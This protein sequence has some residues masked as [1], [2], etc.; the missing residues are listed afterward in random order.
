[1]KDRRAF[2]L[3]TSDLFPHDA[4]CPQQPD[5]RF[6]VSQS[7]EA[8]HVKAVTARAQPL[9]S[10]RKGMFQISAAQEMTGESLARR[11]KSLM[12]S[13]ENT[14]VALLIRAEEEDDH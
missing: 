10:W 3:F 1:M 6:A 4:D 11:R 8:C 2:R 14:G 7:S 12:A 5:P 9:P 13:A